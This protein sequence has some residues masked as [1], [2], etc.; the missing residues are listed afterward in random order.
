MGSMAP[1]QCYLCG[2]GK[3]GY[4]PEPYS[5]P[6]CMDCIVPL[7]KVAVFRPERNR[8]Q[9]RARAWLALGRQWRPD[10]EGAKPETEAGTQKACRPQAE[11]D[12]VVEV[13][14]TEGIAILIA[15]ILLKM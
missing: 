15:K 4:I 11:A 14:Q 3:A 10:V 1:V 12:T 13:F 8:L 9:R 7:C 6:M 2:K 5:L